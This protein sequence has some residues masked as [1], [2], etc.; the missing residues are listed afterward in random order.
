M[1]FLI[2]SFIIITLVRFND[3]IDLDDMVNKVP[4]MV[5]KV[6]RSNPNSISLIM[7]Q[8][9]QKNHNL[10]QKFVLMLMLFKIIQ[11]LGMTP[12]QLPQLHLYLE[13]DENTLRVS[14]FCSKMVMYNK[15]YSTQ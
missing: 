3:V 7:A 5:Q 15:Y 9:I 8:A 14:H 6:A 1:S 12:T 10:Q 4:N 11:L 13:V 2:F